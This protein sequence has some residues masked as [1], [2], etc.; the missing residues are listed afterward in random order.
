MHEFHNNIPEPL[1]LR[2]RWFDNSTKLFLVPAASDHT[3]AANSLTET[4]K[5]KKSGAACRRK[6]ARVCRWDTYSTS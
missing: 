4:I 1:D 2:R 3:A 6:L 5:V